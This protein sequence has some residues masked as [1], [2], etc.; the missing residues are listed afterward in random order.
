MRQSLVITT[1]CGWKFLNINLQ[2]K[3]SEI[4]RQNVYVENVPISNQSRQHIVYTID[5]VQPCIKRMF[6]ITA[7]N[8]FPSTWHMHILLAVWTNRRHCDWVCGAV[9][10]IE[11][12]LDGA[13]YW[14]SA[15]QPTASIFH[16]LV[17]I[18]LAHSNTNSLAPSLNPFGSSIHRPATQLKLIEMS[19]FWLGKHNENERYFQLLSKG[20]RHATN[21]N[22][23]YIARSTHRVP[24]CV[25]FVHNKST[26]ELAC[27]HH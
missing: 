10:L 12:L 15:Y 19:S 23:F 21:S 25:Q 22:R 13:V 1:H 3:T 14:C 9:V 27:G 8:W 4:A 5:C 18:E 11:A 26:I 6:S 17:L 24:L 7:H 20:E 16:P 2:F